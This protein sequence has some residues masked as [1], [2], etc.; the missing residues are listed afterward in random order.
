MQQAVIPCGMVRMAGSSSSIALPQ[1]HKAAWDIAA[2]PEHG[3]IWGSQGFLLCQAIGN[4]EK[5]ATKWM[6]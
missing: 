3:A 2:H 1:H 6:G 4:Q 5:S